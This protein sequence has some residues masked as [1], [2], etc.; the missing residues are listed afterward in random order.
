[1]RS[2]RADAQDRLVDIPKTRWA[3]TIDDAYI[4][5]QDFGDGPITLIVIHGWTSHLEVDWE[6]PRY[7]RFMRRLASNM[8]ILNFDKRGTGMSDRFAQPPDLDVRMDDV[9]AVM[10]AAAVERAALLGWGTGG[11]PLAVFFA[12][13]HPE[14]TIALCIDPAVY[15][16]WY[17]VGMDT[18]ERERGLAEMMATW[19]EESSNAEG[20]DDAPN[21]PE[22]IRWN[23]KSGRFSATPGSMAALTRMWSETD[24]RDILP[25]ACRP[26]C[27]TRP[28]RDRG[29]TPRW[30]RG[31]S[32]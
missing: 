23:A 19:G 11:P 7:A 30:P 2:G 22:F 13:T 15:E 21:D 3:K 12:A 29:L 9:R 28:G 1:M 18:D 14:R 26:W 32:N 5:Y 25:T 17:S 20:Y 27:S 10:D 24:V 8:R 4:A 6:Q 31:S 16:G